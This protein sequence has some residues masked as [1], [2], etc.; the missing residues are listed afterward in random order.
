[1]PSANHHP[2]RLAVSVTAYFEPVNGGYVTSCDVSA[3]AVATSPLLVGAVE[4]GGVAHANPCSD[5]LQGQRLTT[6]APQAGGISAPGRITSR[7]PG[8]RSTEGRSP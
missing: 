8:D 3:E 1:M 5:G 6:H 7:P 2:S 4:P